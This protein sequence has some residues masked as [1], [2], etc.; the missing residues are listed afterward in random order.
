MLLNIHT[1][2]PTPDGERTVRA[3]GL[4]PWNLTSQWRQTWETLCTALVSP[5]L[6]SI[7]LPNESDTFYSSPS[8]PLF[9]GE[10]GLDKVCDT[11]YPLQ[12]QAF[13]TQIEYAEQHHLPLILHCV[14]AMD[15]A[16]ALHRSTTQPWVWHGFRGKPEQLRQ[17][18]REG[19]Y[20]SFGWH[21]N[22]DSLRLCPANRLFLETDD[23]PSSI[24]P[25]YEQV[26]DIRRTSIKALASQM[27]LNL[28]NVCRHIHQ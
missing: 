5:L 24:A 21:F 22:Q 23:G 17:L 13:Q 15:D 20:I 28:M 19:F 7:P 9:I 25:L 10:C 16:I 26:A 8:N 1:H 2:L 18:L 27:E 3:V 14:R 4:H 12:L 11:P 6:K